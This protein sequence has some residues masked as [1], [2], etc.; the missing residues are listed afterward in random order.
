MG[1]KTVHHPPYV[2]FGYSLSS[3]AVIMTQL[4]KWKRLWRSSLTR[5]RK[6]TLMGPSSSCWNGTTS[7][8]QLEE[9]TSKETSVYYQ[10]EKSQETYLMILIYICGWIYVGLRV[11]V[12]RW[13]KRASYLRY[14][15]SGT[16]VSRRPSFVYFG[17][18]STQSWACKKKLQNRKRRMYVS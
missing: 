1:I 8:L 13:S 12:D 5:S 17:A 10:Y 3:E 2:T 4:R 16:R 18:K 7:A 6:R 14:L 11:F 15:W 9:I